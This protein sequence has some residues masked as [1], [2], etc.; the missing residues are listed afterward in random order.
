GN[1]QI[2]GIIGLAVVALLGLAWWG[3]NDSANA[4]AQMADPG[5]GGGMAADTGSYYAG[6]IVEGAADAPITVIEYASMTCPHCANFHTSIY[7]EL[8]AKYVETGKVRFIFREFP[9]DGLALRAAM[10]ARCGGAERVHGYLDV[11][12]MQQGKWA[13][14]QDP[15]AALSRIARLGG[16]SEAAFQS[17]MANE[18]LAEM[19]V[20][21]RVK[22]SEE[23]DITSTPSFV[24]GGKTYSGGLGVEEFDKILA[25]YLGEG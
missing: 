3:L 21:S 22:G 4:D 13:T 2:F 14:A 23:F 9:L 6:D 7:P 12:F 11:L 25:P 16:M 15:I 1:K 10:L 24:I 19:V 8:R 17:C 18:P 20:A 5:D